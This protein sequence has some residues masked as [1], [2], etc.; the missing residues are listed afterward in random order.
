VRRSVLLPIGNALLSFAPR[1][2]FLFYVLD[3][4]FAERESSSL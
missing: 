1:R 2:K 4:W 3:D